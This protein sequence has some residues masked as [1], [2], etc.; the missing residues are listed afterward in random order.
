MLA[1][2][3]WSYAGVVGG[4]RQS[5]KFHSFAFAV[6][7]LLLGTFNGYLWIVRPWLYRVRRGSMDGYRFVSG[8]PLFGTLCVVA[9]GILGFGELPTALTGL[10]ATAVDTGGLHWFL[11]ATWRD[12]TLWDA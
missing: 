5:V 12:E 4:D 10:G 2:I 1:S 8:L 7:G 3:L 11:F 6:L 9:S